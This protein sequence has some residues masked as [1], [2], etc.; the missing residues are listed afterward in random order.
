MAEYQGQ[1]EEVIAKEITIAIINKMGIIGHINSDPVDN[2][3][4]MYDKIYKQ[5]IASTNNK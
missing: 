5:V 1:T 4:K 3:C 2:A